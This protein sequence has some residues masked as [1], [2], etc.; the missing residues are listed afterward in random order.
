VILFPGEEYS[1][2]QGAKT[3]RVFVNYTDLE[4]LCD[5]LVI[6]FPKRV[7]DTHAKAQSRKG[8]LSITPIWKNFAS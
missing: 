4:K 1:S 5:F 3:Q 7:K 2:R 6:P 8:L